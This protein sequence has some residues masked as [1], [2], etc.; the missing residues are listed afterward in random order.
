MAQRVANLGQA[1]AITA[2]LLCVPLALTLINPDASLR[3]GQGGGF[4]WMPGDF[5]L[6]GALILGLILGL[7]IITHYLQNAWMRYAA[8]FV[9]LAI[10][11]LVWAELAVG[12][13][14][15]VLLSST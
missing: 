4:D 10:G 6:M 14:S 7:Q 8:G 9:F 15:Q 3:G 12:I 11:L 2:L 13:V 1:V 5:V